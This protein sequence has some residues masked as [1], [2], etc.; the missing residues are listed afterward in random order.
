MSVV[1]RIPQPLVLAA[2]LAYSGA[3]NASTPETLVRGEM[4]VRQ[5]IRERTKGLF[6]ARR[7]EELDRLYVQYVQDAERT[8]S[9]L[10][11]STLVHK[12]LEDRLRA[13]AD[14]GG[15][16]ITQAA[17]MEWRKQLPK[18][19]LARLTE[20]SLYS[21][22]GWRI[23]GGGFSGTVA[24]ESWKPFHDWQ[25]RAERLLES[26][27]ASLSSLPDY[28]TLLIDTKKALGKDPQSA[29]ENGI[30]QFPGYYEIHFSML[31]YLLPRWHGGAAEIE[32]FAREATESSRGTDGAGMYA[33]IYWYASQAEYHEK[34]FSE[35][36]ANWPRMRASF[37]EVIGRYPDQWNLQ[38]YGK[39]AC[40]AKDMDTLSRLFDRIVEPAI[41]SAW[42]GDETYRTC[43]RMVR[44]DG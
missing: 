40:H 22:R 21:Q 14:E 19:K 33:R 32:R 37:D 20:A 35:S 2:I 26:E 17:L 10:W 36:L 44:L 16:P 5:E 28:H 38:N 25:E 13:Q 29:Y 6:S 34:L 30:K 42:G 23:R 27:A 4:Q 24:E 15:L 3:A 43:K 1:K 39:F 8:P 9:G 41:D 12:A 7:W 18:S 31:A 11:K